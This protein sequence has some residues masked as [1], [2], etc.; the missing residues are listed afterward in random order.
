[1]IRALKVVALA[2]ALA[3]LAG[4]REARA[5]ELATLDV[6]A[7]DDA[8]TCDDAELVRAKVAERLGRD[9]FQR[10]GADPEAKPFARLRVSFA[11]DKVAWTAEIALLD[12]EG[13]RTGARTLSRD[14][15]TCEPLVAS[16]V[17]TVAVLLEELAPRRP[18]RPAPAPPAGPGPGDDPWREP[19][20]P[21]A[22][23]PLPPAVQPRFDAS[24]GAAGAIGTA[25]A[26]SVGGE[27][28]VGLD[29]KRLRVELGGR[30]YLPASSD[31]DVAVRT[32]LVYGRLAPCYGWEVLSACFV[33]AVGSVSGEAT[34]E[35]VASSSLDGQVYAAGGFGALSRF[36]LVS[37]RVFVRAA[38]D[39]LFPLSRVGFDVGDRRVWTVPVVS[40]ASVLGVGVRLP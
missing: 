2:L 10:G 3:C 17:F 7:K 5:G 21:D 8:R 37:D 35:R 28:V 25:P 38:I 14:G 16:V 13:K 20:A 40:A 9:P 36:F 6:D 12:S 32:R 30:I 33:A 23:R 19:P 11:R 24:L 26:P 39:L 34:G 22:P 27:I 4:A 31:G 18:E 1:V 29:V 15:A